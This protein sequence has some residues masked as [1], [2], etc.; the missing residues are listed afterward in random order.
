MFRSVLLAS[1][2]LAAT[3]PA[4]AETQAIMVGNLIPDAVT[5]PTGPAVILV[6]NGRIKDIAKGTTNPFQADTVVD[7]SLIHI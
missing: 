4:M 7:L 3:T 1:I 2:A 5:G 6:E